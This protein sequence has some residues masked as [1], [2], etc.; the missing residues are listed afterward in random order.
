MQML[1]KKPETSGAERTCQ[2]RAFAVMFMTDSGRLITSAPSTLWL[3]LSTVWRY[4]YCCVLSPI[5]STNTFTEDFTVVFSSFVMAV[6]CYGHTCCLYL[7]HNPA[8]TVGKKKRWQICLWL[9]WINSGTSLALLDSSPWGCKH[10]LLVCTIGASKSS[11]QTVPAATSSSV[12]STVCVSTLIWSLHCMQ[13]P[14]LS[15]C[16]AAI[17]PQA[18]EAS[19][20]RTRHILLNGCG[21]C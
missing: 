10:C 20:N 19:L 18:P 8:A 14:R 17:M 12:S 3:Q 11:Y 16:N 7:L 1:E 4:K 2:Y 21:M 9:M 6:S 5:N 15:W 13:L